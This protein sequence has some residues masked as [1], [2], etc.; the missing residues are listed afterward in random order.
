MLVGCVWVCVR[1]V[2]VF[3]SSPRVLG[4]QPP[5]MCQLIASGTACIYW[6]TSMGMKV[7]SKRCC[8]HHPL[9]GVSR[10]SNTYRANPNRGA[11]SYRYLLA[12]LAF[13]YRDR[14]QSTALATTLVGNIVSSFKA[15]KMVAC[16]SLPW[17]NN[18]PLSISSP[19][20]TPPADLSLLSL[21]QGTRCP[22]PRFHG[23]RGTGTTSGRIRNKAVVTTAAGSSTTSGGVKRVPLAT[24]PLPS[25]AHPGDRIRAGEDWW[26][27]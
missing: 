15:V 12:A 11:R 24:L 23:K 16:A 4:M 14:P 13:D 6:S 17:S 1:R 9:Q 10:Q 5:Q 18:P 26:R 20:P 21:T 7:V 3:F 8:R 27:R 19:P 2:F 25:L 22:R